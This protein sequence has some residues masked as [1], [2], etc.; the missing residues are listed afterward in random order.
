[1]G[2]SLRAGLSVYTP[3][4]LRRKAGIHCY[5]LHGG[6]ETRGQFTPVLR[7]CKFF[8]KL[9]YIVYLTMVEHLIHYK[10]KGRWVIGMPFLIGFILFVL[11]SVYEI[12]DRYNGAILL[13]LSGIILF[14]MDNKRVKVYEGEIVQRTIM[15]P[16]LKRQNTFMWIELKY[17]AV[18][19]GLVGLVWLVNCLILSNS[20]QL[21]Y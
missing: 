9:R 2:V 6:R 17:C 8:K 10:G 15:L 1:L 3:A 12:N 18:A 16:R 7:Q 20:L 4:G 5:P 13:I 14:I 21:L 11:T 19:M